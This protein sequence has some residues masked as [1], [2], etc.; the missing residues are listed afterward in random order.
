MIIPFC[1]PA[2][3]RLRP[4]DYL[5]FEGSLGYIANPKLMQAYM[6]RPPLKKPKKATENNSF[7]LAYNG[8]VNKR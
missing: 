8:E 1:N 3:K 5:E 7:C 6:A 4:A 2:L